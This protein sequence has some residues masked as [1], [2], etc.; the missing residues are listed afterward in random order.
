MK[1]KVEN[2]EFAYNSVPVLE[3]I[4]IELNNSEIL[5]IVGPNGTGKS[6]LIRCIDQILNPKKGKILLDGQN[7]SKMTRMEI[8]KK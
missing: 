7:L 2:I 3:N 6:T 5:G 1:L 8:A 4:S